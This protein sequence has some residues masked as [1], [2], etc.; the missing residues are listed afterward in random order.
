[1]SNDVPSAS[2]ASDAGPAPATGP[3]PTTGVGIPNEVSPLRRV[4]VHRPGPEMDRLTPDNHDRYL[5]DEIL[6]LERAHA[7][8]DAF[9]SVL[10]DEGAEVLVFADL[11]AEV[12]AIPEARGELLAETLD[13]QVFGDIAVQDLAE[14]LAELPSQVLAHHL[15]AGVTR[16]ELEDV[17]ERAGHA[18]RSIS[19]GLAPA[20]RLVLDP[21]PNHLFTRDTSAWIGSGVAV[22]SM[23]MPARRR[24]SV[25]LRTIYRHHPAFRDAQG[26]PPHLYTSGLGGVRT[27][28]E[29][30]DV[31][32]LSVVTIVVGLSER[33]GAAGVELLAGHV[34]AGG[35]TQRVIALAMPHRRSM[36][37]LDTVMT[38]VDHES[39]IRYAGLPA[40]PS[41]EI[42]REGDRLR[43]RT[44]DA[45]EMDR[46][47]AAG[48]G[49]DSLR[50][51]VPP[52]DAHA[53]AREQ[54]DDGCNVLA[55]APGRVVTYERAARTNDFLRSQG[56]EVLEIDGGELGRGRGGPRCMTCPVLRTAE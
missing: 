12:L 4:I 20:D 33:T 54:W 16:G 55:V 2:P 15:I 8:H 31:L 14:A 5:F 49:I 23:R 30:G 22:N 45:E 21:L 34:L 27:A 6:W 13:P 50:V 35:G 1:M 9:R 38:L 25:H 32:V 40:L 17:H 56:V 53:A 19:L 47:L 18:L 44:H 52:M 36:M 46:V 7:E 24:E 10:A 3:T 48:L 42:T 43:T 39:V 37:H 51:L 28:V 29:G 26:A 41:F 11:L